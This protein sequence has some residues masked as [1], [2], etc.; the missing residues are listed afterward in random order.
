MILESIISTLLSIASPTSATIVFAGDAM[1]HQKQLDVATSEGKYDFTA[2]FEEIAPWVSQADYAVVNLETPLGDSNFSGY[3]QFNAPY[4]YGEALKAA[5]FDMMLTANN[6][7]LD[8]RDAG[9]RR[10]IALLDSLQ[11]D[12]IGTYGNPAERKKAIPFIK[13]IKGFKVGFLNYTYGT[14]G[15]SPQ[16]DVVVDLIDREKIKNDIKATRDAGAE[17]VVVAIHWGIEYVLLPP[18]EVKATADFLCAQDVDMVIGGH[19]H[20]I[21][22]MEVRQNTTTGKPVLLVYSMGNL[23]SNMTTRDTRGGA[24]VKTVIER[25]ADGNARFGSAEYMPHF[26]VPGT[27]VTNNYRVVMLP[28]NECV[29]TSIPA[30]WRSHA[31]AWLNSVIPVFDKNNINV[32]RAGNGRSLTSTQ[33]DETKDSSQITPSR[34]LNGALKSILSLMAQQ[35]LLML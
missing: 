9:L 8:R 24:M 33:P 28:T 21:Q 6:H 29:N 22:P 1:Q 26:T 15:I 27:S 3:P 35:H 10:T 12:H 2:C 18:A 7:T 13:N 5:G 19:P 17:L 16:G 31:N 23:I 20:V 4:A 11:V 32:P 30:S 34:F 14:N 25:D